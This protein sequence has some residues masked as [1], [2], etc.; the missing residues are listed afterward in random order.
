MSPPQVMGA[1]MLG[2]LCRA[3]GKLE[4]VQ[5]GLYGCHAMQPAVVMF[6]AE[7]ACVVGA[8]QLD[9]R[10]LGCPP[11]AK[12]LNSLTGVTVNVNGGEP[13]AGELVHHPG[14]RQT[15]ERVV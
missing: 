2:G 15:S 11:D 1:Q 3:L 5:V 8:D 13:E 14:C 9:V 10:A 6:T 12:A 4:Q 7:N